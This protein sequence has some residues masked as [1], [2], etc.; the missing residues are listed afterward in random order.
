MKKPPLSL[1]REGQLENCSRPLWRRAGAVTFNTATFID[2]RLVFDRGK[3]AANYVCGFFL[4]DFISSLP[5]AY[6]SPQQ[7]GVSLSFATRDPS[8]AILKCLCFPSIEKK[9]SP[10]RASLP[11]RGGKGVDAATRF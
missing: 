5:I 9:P 4:I 8:G 10:R 11:S 1:E 3:I 7:I 6:T 2:G